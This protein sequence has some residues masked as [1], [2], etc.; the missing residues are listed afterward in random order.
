[1]VEHDRLSQVIWVKGLMVECP[2]HNALPDCPANEL[3]TLPLTQRIAAV[4]AMSESALQQ[5]MAHHREC[6]A[7]REQVE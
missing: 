5:I 2:L 3:R 6:I 1:M 4:D 7:K